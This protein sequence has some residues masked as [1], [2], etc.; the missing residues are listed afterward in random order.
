MLFIEV[1]Y[2]TRFGQISSNPWSL[3]YCTNCCMKDTLHNAV[4]RA[5]KKSITLLLPW[6]RTLSY[7]TSV[8]LTAKTSA[9]LLT[10]V[11][12]EFDKWIQI[13]A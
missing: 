9:D 3:A 4:R 7:K 8:W 12:V 6:C 2:L 11:N 10:T 1:S 13:S 5:S